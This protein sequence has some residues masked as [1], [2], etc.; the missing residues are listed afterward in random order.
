MLGHGMG[1]F[2]DAVG[3]PMPMTL[4][5]ATAILNAARGKNT[6]MLEFVLTDAISGLTTTPCPWCAGFRVQQMPHKAAKIPS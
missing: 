1:A 2:N 6:P 5:D 3:K 4:F